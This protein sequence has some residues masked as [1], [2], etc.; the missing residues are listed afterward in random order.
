MTA[1]RLL[2]GA[3]GPDEP[4]IAAA[5]RRARDAGAE[6]VYL[7]AQVSAEALAAAAIG[8]DVAAVVVDPAGVEP[9]TEALERA[10]AA[11]IEVRATS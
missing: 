11:D 2:L 3:L 5:A 8:E 1:E 10:G 6:V 4:S 9:V 7:G